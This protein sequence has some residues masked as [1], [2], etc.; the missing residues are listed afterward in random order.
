M[1]SSFSLTDVPLIAPSYR[2][3]SRLPISSEKDY[4]AFYQRSIEHVGAYWATVAQ[5]LVWDQMWHADMQGELPNFEFF[6]NGYLNVSANCI[7][8]HAQRHPHRQALK[9]ISETGEEKTWTYSQLLDQTA[10]MASFLRQQGIQPGDVVAIFLPN[11]LETFAAV[12]ACYRIGA[13]YNIIFS[14]FSQEALYD[15]LVETKPRIIITADGT[16][17]RGRI[18]PLK[19]TLDRIVERIDSVEHVIVIRRANT[20]VTMTRPRDIFWDDILHDVTTYQDPLP[21][22][23]NQPGFIIYTSGTT[24]KPKGLI[25]SGAGFLVGAYHNV[26]F[27]LDL[28]ENDVYWCTADTGWLTFPIFELVGGLA[29]GASMIVYEGAMDYPTPAHFYQILSHNQ[30]TKIF[31]AP[32]WLRMLARFGESLAHEYALDT[33]QLIGLVGEPL[34]ANT[35]QW[36]RQHLGS[37]QVDIN[38]TY[39]QSET[40]S[41][42][43]SGIAG[44]TAMKPGSCG[45][46]LPGH[47]YQIVNANGEPEA[48]NTAGTLVLTQPFPALTRGIWGNR[49]RYYTQYFS[50]YPGRYNTFDTAVED[51]NRHLWVLGRI[52]DVINVAAHRLSTMEMES[53]ILQLPGVAESAVIGVDDTLKGQVPVAF[54]TLRDNSLKQEN[55]NAKVGEQISQQIGSIARPAQVY[56]ID[57][58]PKTRSGKIVRRLLKEIVTT[59]RAEGDRTGME[60]PEIV[61]TLV[62]QLQDAIHR[63]GDNS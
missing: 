11:L 12:H 42:W 63:Q 17:R 59:G 9:W 1:G 2:P 54:V 48:L 51:S 22:E 36:V 14:G 46:A 15:R 47:A 16:Y 55:W 31:T 23:A 43:A 19:Q 34:D 37:G 33:L 29:H 62:A 44:V 8:R 10:R 45:P 25:H 40:G 57:A 20:A 32:T 30:V 35:W 6:K 28:G 18:I 58:M 53:V 27:T 13:I 24:S 39:G 56:V 7:D 3:S 60:N 26:K 41:A 49:E 4:P 61:D 5:E 50:Q 21:I 52:D 38:N